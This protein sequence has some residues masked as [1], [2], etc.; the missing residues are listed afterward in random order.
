MDDAGFPADAAAAC[1]TVGKTA[2]LASNESLYNHSW[3][4][5]ASRNSFF[6][7]AVATADYLSHSFISGI[8][9]SLAISV[10]HMQQAGAHTPSA[11]NRSPPSPSLAG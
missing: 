3:D 2:I 10:V 9:S 8:R 11:P 7:E 4:F 6:S 5:V 1:I